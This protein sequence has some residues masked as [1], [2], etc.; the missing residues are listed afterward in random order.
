MLKTFRA[1][2]AAAAATLTIA[3][4]PVAAENQDILIMENAFFP[5]LSYVQP[6]DTITFINMSGIERAV[7][8]TD[9]SWTT[10]SLSDGDSSVVN[11]VEQMEKN[12][13][14]SL[15]NETEGDEEAIGNGEDGALTDDNVLTDDTA[16]ADPE[17]EEN[18]IL[19]KLNFA[20]PPQ[21][22]SN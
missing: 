12:F 18:L 16:A 9:A 22:S 6:G 2:A 17:T 4:S 13:R 20:A 21:F 19:G 8:A 14:I 5:E 15:T 1:G 7:Q 3:T 11:V 10:E